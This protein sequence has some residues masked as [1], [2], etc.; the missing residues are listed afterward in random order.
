MRC[1][2][3]SK[4]PRTNSGY[5]CTKEM[6]RA[7]YTR[8]WEFRTRTRI[9]LTKDIRQR[10]AP[11][12]SKRKKIRP[13]KCRAKAFSRSSA[14]FTHKNE[15]AAGRLLDAGGF[16]RVFLIYSRALPRC[17][18]PYCRIREHGHLFPGRSTQHIGPADLLADDALV[19]EVKV[20]TDA[21]RAES[22]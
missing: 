4:I 21:H 5:G 12:R 11:R 13:L 20:T 18:R 10:H 6:I 14:P 16:R 2:F 1:H 22:P 3:R 8:L 19:A 15:K 9:A 17:A 7:A